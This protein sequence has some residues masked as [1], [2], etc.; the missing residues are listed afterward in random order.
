MINIKKK[1]KYKNYKK[2]LNLI[3][4]WISIQKIKDNGFN[5]TYIYQMVLLLYIT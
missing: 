3:S 5:Q 4:L 2:I 1:F